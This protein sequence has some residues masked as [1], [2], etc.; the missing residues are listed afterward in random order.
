MLRIL[1][2][3]SLNGGCRK[4]KSRR[5]R[6]SSRKP[7]TNWLPNR[8]CSKEEAKTCKLTT[9]LTCSGWKESRRAAKK[10]NHNC[11]KDAQKAQM[12]L[13]NRI[14]NLFCAFCASLWP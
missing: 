9:A 14:H 2:R 3:E 13:A 12:D 4:R 1:S 7:W 8:W 11:H 10:Q 5:D 6:P